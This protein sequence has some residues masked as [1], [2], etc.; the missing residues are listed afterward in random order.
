M[1]V[2]TNTISYLTRLSFLS[3]DGMVQ[4]RYEHRNPII[5]AFVALCEETYIGP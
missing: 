2:Q 4:K 5:R 1:K 3:F